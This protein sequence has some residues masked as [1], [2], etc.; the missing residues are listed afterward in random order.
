MNNNEIMNNE[1]VEA[2]EEVIENAG[3]GK[4]VK[5]AAGIGLSVV[6]GVVVYKYVA[7]PVIANIKAQIEQKKMAAEENTVSWKNLMLSLKTTK[8]ANLRSS[9]KGKHL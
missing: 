9:D 6:V 2:T 7:K 3:L 4:G 1:V 8:N 5:I